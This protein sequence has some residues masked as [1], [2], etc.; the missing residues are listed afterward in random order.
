MYTCIHRHIYTYIHIHI[1]SYMDIYLYTYA[2]VCTYTYIYLYM[3]MHTY[4]YVSPQLVHARLCNG[5]AA[6][7]PWKLLQTY[8]ESCGTSCMLSFQPALLPLRQAGRP[9][10]G[11]LPDTVRL[12]NLSKSTLA[13]DAVAAVVTVLHKLHPIIRVSAGFIQFVYGS[14]SRM[15]ADLTLDK[16]LFS[17]RF[18][19]DLTC[20]WQEFIFSR[21]QPTYNESESIQS[22]SASEIPPT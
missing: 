5:A 6:S 8:L 18:S 22:I 10:A 4:A 7:L 13:H 21:I 2:Y 1:H 11:P 3:H 20:H 19:R 9:S 16:N 12:R 17:P 15:A 14:H